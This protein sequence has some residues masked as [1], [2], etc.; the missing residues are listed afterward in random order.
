M[1]LSGDFLRS[2]I[3]EE[4]SR[5]HMRK[6]CATSTAA[7]AQQGRGF[8]GVWGRQDR[9]AMH[10]HNGQYLLRR[11]LPQVLRAIPIMN[12]LLFFL[13]QFLSGCNSEFWRRR[14]H[15][16]MT[17]IRSYLILNLYWLSR[18]A[19][20]AR[21]WLYID[22]GQIALTKGNFV[23]GTFQSTFFRLYGSS[24]KFWFDRKFYHRYWSFQR[25]D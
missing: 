19:V 1:N 12:L 2:L 9:S 16:C 6:L 24:L 10:I 21:D 13:I 8:F 18:V 4:D 5:V 23:A 3:H 15:S 20:I 11:F 14:L 25:L 22:G 7:S 17:S